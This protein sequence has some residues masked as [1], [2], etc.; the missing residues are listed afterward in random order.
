M[1]LK[2]QSSSRIKTSG[3][4]QNPAKQVNGGNS[5]QRRWFASLWMS[6][7]HLGTFLTLYQ[8]MEDPIK[9]GFF[10]DAVNPTDEDI[11]RWSYIP[12]A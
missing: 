11:V 4:E 2:L 9:A 3:D 1:D 12:F 10:A 8:E 7:T 6:I 5:G